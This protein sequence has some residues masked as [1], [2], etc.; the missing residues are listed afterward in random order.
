MK[1]GP[2]VAA[3]LAALVA[4]SASCGPR[5]AT[6][7]LPIDFSFSRGG[8][9]HTLAE[10]RG[11][12]LVLVLMRTAEMSSQAYMVEVAAAFR[13][14]GG[15]VRY[16]VLTLEPAE[17]PLVD[18]FVEFMGLPFEMG[19]ADRTV[20]EGKTALGI[21][22]PAPVTLIIDS[23]G[24]IFDAASGV[25]RADELGRAVGRVEGR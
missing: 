13:A 22:P 20:A 14:T 19:V 7:E 8:R 17:A 21:L 18:P 2:S 5:D 1:A 24:R 23:S 11:R 3:A 9:Q 16:L 4:L 12:P 10:L 6:A 25:V 15:K